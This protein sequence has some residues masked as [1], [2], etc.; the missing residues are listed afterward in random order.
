MGRRLRSAVFVLMLGIS[1]FW[2]VIQV[3]YWRRQALSPFH[4]HLQHLKETL[5]GDARVLIVAPESERYNS[6]ILQLNTW[7]HPRP[8]YLLPP[9]VET[10][11]GASDWIREKQL[12]W[13]LSLGGKDYDPRAAYVRRLDDRR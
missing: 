9:G 8:F 6:H 2:A 12:T 11:E 3:R 7:L 1:L 13:A 5:P 10:L 4:V